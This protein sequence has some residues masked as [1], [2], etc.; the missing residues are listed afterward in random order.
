[1]TAVLYLALRL[2][3]E[4]AGETTVITLMRRYRKQHHRTAAHLAMHLQNHRDGTAA[5]PLHKVV[6]MGAGGRGA[7]LLSEDHLPHVFIGTR[8]LKRGTGAAAQLSPTEK[9]VLQ[10]LKAMEKE[11]KVEKGEKAGK[12]MIGTVVVLKVARECRI[13]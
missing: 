3:E 1:M 8:S 6:E 11:G 12:V 7:D 10:L 5:N 4:Y 13:N 2:Q 9:G